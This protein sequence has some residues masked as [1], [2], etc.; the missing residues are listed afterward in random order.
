MA[1]DVLDRFSPATAA[2]FRGSFSAPTPAQAG[3]WEADQQR[4]PR[5][6]RRPDRLGQDPLGVPLGPRPARRAARRPRSGSQRCRVLYVS[7]MKALAVDV[8][9]NLRSPLVGIRHAAPGS[10]CPSPTS[11]SRCGPA[12]PRPTSGAPSPA[13]PSDVLITTPESLFLLLTSRRAGGPRRGRDGHPRRG[14]RPRRHQAR[15]P[16]RALASSASTRCSTRPAQRIGL[17]ATVRPVEEVARFLAG[18][19][20]VE[21]VQPPS[22]KE[23]DLGSSSPSLTCPSSAQP[24]GDLAGRRRRAG[25]ARLDLAARRGAHRRP[26]RRPHLDPRL[27]QQPAPRRAAD[28]PAQRDLGG[29]GRGRRR[30]RG[31]AGA[32]RRRAAA[33][34]PARAPRRRSWPSRGSRRRARRS[35]ARAHHGSVSKEQRGR[36]R[37]GAEVRAAARRRRDEQPRARHRHGRGRPRRPGRV[38]AVGR[39]RAAAGRAGRAP[40]RRRL[41]R[42]CSSRSSA[43]TSCRPPSSSS[44]CS[45]GAHRGAARPAN[46]LDVLAQQVVAMCALDEWTVDDVLALARRAAPYATLTRPRPRV[47]PRHARRAVPERGLRRAAGPDHLGPAVRHAHRPP[48]RAAA[49]RHL[50]RHDPRPRP[51]RRLPRHAARAPAAGSA[52]ST[53][54]WSTSPGSVTCSPSGRARGGSRTSPTTGCSSP[55]PPGCPA[56][57]RS[58]RATRL[59]RPAELGRAVGAFVREVEAL[60]PQAARERVM[61]AGLDDVGRR[62]PAHL[63]RASSGRPPGTSPTTARSSSSASATSSATGGSPSTPPSAPRCTRRGRWRLGARMRDG[64]GVDVQ[65]M[66]GDDGIVLRLPDLECGRRRGRRPARGRAASCSTSS[67]LDPDDVRGLVT[68]RDRRVGALRLPLPRVRRPRPAAA[69]AAPRPAPAAVAAAPAGRAAARGGEPLP[70][71]PDRPRG[72]PRVRPGRL[73]RAGARRADARRRRAAGHRRRGRVH[74]RR[75]RSPSRCSS[76]TSPSS[77][78]RA[79]ARSPSGGPRRSPSTPRCSPSC[80]ARSEGLALRDLLD[81][82]QV[83]RTEAE[84]QRLTPERAGPRRRGRPRPAPR[85]RAAVR[86]GRRSSAA[87]RASPAPTSRRWLAGLEGRA[88]SSPCGWPARSGGRPSRTPPGCATPSGPPCRPACPQAFLEPVADPLGDLVARY[89]R[90][91]APFHAAEVARAYGLGRRRGRRRAAPGWSRAGG[92]VEGE[93]L[94]TGGRVHRVLRRRGAADAAPALARRAAGRGRAGHPRRLRRASSREWQGV[95]GRLRGRDGVLRVGRA[96][97]RRRAAGQRRR[98]PRPARRGSPTTPPRLLDELMAA[99]RCC[100]AGTGRC[101]ATT[102]GCRCTS[103]TPRT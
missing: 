29:A 47:R 22:A 89:A 58:G 23:W 9:R 17:S 103:P 96:A 27:R 99:A 69:P 20:P 64:F 42:A 33:R 1:G 75:R 10:A 65:A 97:E 90:T 88:R 41:P 62:Q 32:R 53:R 3:A 59:G 30:R 2:W 60:P 79:T 70:D 72:R 78:T 31:R 13:R 61:A 39:L 16:P 81:A 73:R 67:T 46:P 38:A 102:A 82:E 43:A 63:P 54:R 8:E 26:R 94:P 95:G 34:G 68:E 56:A 101:P 7:P 76:A 19:R 55:P 45:P 28:R 84:L 24:T 66:H 36:D 74:A 80:S 50:G 98:V 4:P 51:V 15:R 35:L 49:R 52:S 57:C 5:P 14:P 40:G 87:A 25:A 93:L 12:T 18:G 91:H 21:V 85:A 6:R 11:P 77:S 48:R 71:L 37:G 100:G 83:A 86:R 44:G 92:V